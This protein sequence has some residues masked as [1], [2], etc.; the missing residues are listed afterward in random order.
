MLERAGGFTSQTSAMESTTLRHIRM[1]KASFRTTN[2]PS[3]VLALCEAQIAEI[4][5][6]LEKRRHA[7]PLGKDNYICLHGLML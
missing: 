1:T 6:L 3:V 4:R 2:F 5:A 7:T